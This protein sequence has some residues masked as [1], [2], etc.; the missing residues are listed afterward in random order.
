MIVLLL[1]AWVCNRLL[2]AT[3]R[4]AAGFAAGATPQSSGWFTSVNVSSP[5]IFV[6]AID[7]NLTSYIHDNSTVTPI[8]PANL[9][10]N[11]VR[12]TILQLG[13]FAESQQNALI[14][15]LS[16]ILYTLDFGYELCD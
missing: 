15:N 10:L 12:L 7:V 5:H 2:N 8:F 9:T 14:L 11:T 13:L 16:L 6:A 1:C 3:D 4:F